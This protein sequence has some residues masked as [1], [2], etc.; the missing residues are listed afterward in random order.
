MST[1]ILLALDWCV[2]LSGAK[3]PKPLV[4]RLPSGYQGLPL[5]RA[6]KTHRIG[7]VRFCVGLSRQATIGKHLDRGERF[8][9]HAV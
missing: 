8:L 3:Y 5:L 7:W 4:C 6:Q 9:R 1:S 2:W